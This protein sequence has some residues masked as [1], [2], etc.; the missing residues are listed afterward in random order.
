MFENGVFQIL[1]DS[2]GNLW[3]SCNHGVYRVSKRELNDFA[4]G[5]RSSITS[6][7]YGKSDGM[8]S[9]ECNGGYWPA[10]IKARDGKLWFP[11]QDGVAVVDP[12]AVSINL[13]PP[14]VVIESC[15]VDRA[16][17]PVD[18]PVR[19]EPGQDNIEIQYTGLSFV[20]SEHIQFKYRLEGLDRDWI[21][22]GMRRTAYYSHLPAGNYLFKVIAANSDGIWNTEGRSLPVVVLQRFYRTW[23]FLT[24][25]SL[26]AAGSLLL[27]WKYRISQLER[28]NALQHVFSRQLIASQESERKRIAAEL[29]DSLGQHLV[30][31]KN[32][33]LIS[34]S[35]QASGAAADPPY[36]GDFGR[37]LERPERGQGNLL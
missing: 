13:R 14:P 33:A 36:T 19:I 5:K 26:L 8:L 18:R 1:E 37:G 31:I 10:A 12:A 21:D 20:D 22:A 2:R 16:P 4:A 11:T 27:A 28:A 23:W 29:H 24:L 35:N 6:M 30:V 17:M 25:A 9:L 15:L 32:L 34:L 7:A 3:M